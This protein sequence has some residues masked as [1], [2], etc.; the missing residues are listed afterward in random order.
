MC[1]Q[2]PHP[3]VTHRTLGADAMTQNDALDI[4]WILV[5][6]GLVFV[7]QAGFLCLE[8]GLTRNKNAINVAVKN[9]SDFAVAAILFWLIGFALMFGKTADGWFGTGGFALLADGTLPSEL[10]AFLLFQ[11]MFCATAATIVSGA[12]AERMHFSVYLGLTALVGGFIY[13]VFGHWTWGGAIDGMG[14]GWLNAMGFVDFAGSTVV[15]SLGGWV[16]LAAVLVIGPRTGRFVPGEAPQV[17]PAGNLPV[18]MLG[19]LLLFFGWFGFNG[20]STL[21]L[22]ASVP[23]I[24]VNTAL[25]AAGGI[26]T[27]IFLGWRV[28]GYCEVLYALNGAIA[29]LV[30]I[31]A[32]AHVVSGD[33]AIVI[34]AI[35]SVVMV[36]CNE[37]LL[38]RRIDD[39]VGAIPAHLAAGVW[40]T[41]AVAL[42]GDPALIGTGLGR[43]EQLGVQA[44]GVVVCGLW[45]FVI[46]W[47]ALTG[48]S[49]FTRLRVSEEDER[50]GLNVSEHGARTEL[51]MLLETMETHG[52]TGNLTGRVP[53]EPFTEVGQI[54]SAYNRVIVA[55]EEA[56]DQTRAIIRDVRDGIITFTHDGVL[57]SLNPGA[58]KLFGV[59]G[60]GMVGQPVM[61][62]LEVE[63]LPP[64]FQ[65][66]RLFTPGEKIE[67]K[68]GMSRHARRVL[69][70]SVSDTRHGADPLLTGMV[71][72]I[73]E[74]KQV[75]AQ[76]H[77]ERDLAQVTLAS[78]GDGVITT[79]ESGLI[80]YM[81]PVAERLTGWRV[82]E[83]R[84]QAVSIV[85]RVID[86]KSGENLPNPVRG[87]LT[88]GQVMPRMEHAYLLRR[89]GERV[90]VLDSAAPIRSREGFLIGAVLVFHDVTVTLNLAREL[91]HQA[92]HDALTGVPNRRE[93]ERRLAELLLRPR[94]DD[95]T[96]ILCYL[97]LDQFK[98]V[99]DTCGH[100]AGDELLRQV[101]NLLRE[102][103]R[104]ADLLARLGG[105]E[106][107]L[108]LQGC[109]LDQ[110]LGLAERIREAIQ[111]YR[112]AW[113]GK[114]FSIGVSIGLVEIASDDADL[115]M[116]L[117]SADAACYAAKEDG[118]NRVHVYQPDD[119]ALMEQ[120]GQMQW[121][122][123]LQAAL[124]QDRLRLYVQPIVPLHAPEVNPMH[125]EIL[126]RLEE[127]G[128]MISP[129]SFLPA[130]ERYNL[131]PRIDQ[132]V[133]NN[134]LAWLGDR[135]RKQ[136]A[137]E[138][139]YCINLSGASLSDERFRQTLRITL[140]NLRLPAGAICFEIT[141][142]AA[143][144]NLSK[145][146]NFI[147]E[148]KQLGC[149]FALDDFGSGLSSFAYLKNLPV[150]FL[151]I[152]GSFIKDV[153]RDPIDLAMVQAIN[154]IGHVM[155]LKTIAEFVE[156][157]A[158]LQRLVD[159][160]LDYAQGYHLGAPRPLADDDQVRMMPR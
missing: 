148:V 58:E 143:V 125:F 71:R 151:K 70:V 44:L 132:W 160:G 52:K 23:G 15:H 98:V 42:F 61:R 56:T 7:M 77:K 114:T 43:F 37:W 140:E 72:D 144:A 84:G 94:D 67:V 54:A 133:V 68:L 153:E 119:D 102:Q 127:N 135:Y 111:D 20:G 136:G 29:G 21:A 156:N 4:L 128:K 103:L 107:G 34:G 120:H 83:A 10:L 36:F 33:E 51:I 95:R 78:I 146:V 18:A 60:A 122:G 149:S 137:L 57:T 159:I 66:E 13:P 90:P 74:R 79:D 130:A 138:G 11:L 154:A 155:G 129:G 50:V 55:L 88:K 145:V 1:P 59:A 47:L 158:I 108:I 101:A 124:D 82:H 19:V 45:A 141:E 105:D 24:M 25:A 110:A 113:E 100:I 96:D 2:W 92:S 46:A 142:T 109:P 49:R 40:G 116:V 14:Q 131:M 117:S 17:I 121:V 99:N 8:S 118:R 115:G 64:S 76:L 152:D 38:K 126:V 106:F 32:C 69:E 112:F 87:V 39:A 75:E 12:V 26:L 5:C 104:T 73:T 16:A 65:P 147:L 89:D 139:V 48:L 123:R 3:A 53:V 150:D 157:E 9:V 85:Y 28:H 31:T 35:G 91:S 6:A 86:D 41:L 62:L 134:T 30:S 27:G 63:G 93:F 22:N 80:Q 97:D 81:N